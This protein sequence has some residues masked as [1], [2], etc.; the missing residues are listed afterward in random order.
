MRQVSPFGTLDNVI[1]RHRQMDNYF[2]PEAFMWRAFESLALAGLFMERG[3]VGPT[4]PGH[5]ELIVHRDM[6]FGNVF[7]GLNSSDTW[8]GY[9][10]VKLG[11]FGNCEVVPKDVVRAS[12][13]FP[14]RRYHHQS[15]E[16]RTDHILDAD[17]QGFENPQRLTSR[18]NGT[19]RRHLF[20]RV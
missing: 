11:D 6:K 12:N 17:A 20:D 18:T 10:S 2:A 9:P 15:P 1:P 4:P 13:A 5:W 19:L 16:E 14:L 8:R 7:L 3:G